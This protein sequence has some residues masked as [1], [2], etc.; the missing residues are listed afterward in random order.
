LCFAAPAAFLGAAALF[1]TDTRAEDF[2]LLVVRF[3]GD[4]FLATFFLAIRYRTNGKGLRQYSE[5]LA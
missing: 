5:T 3:F 4:A 2:E 1:R